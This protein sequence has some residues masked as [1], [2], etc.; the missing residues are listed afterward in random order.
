MRLNEQ[1]PPLAKILAAIPLVVRGAHADYTHLSWT[2][3]GSGKFPF[4]Q[5]FLGEWVFGHWFLMTWNDPH[6]TL[7]WARIPMLLLTL[8]L[9]LVP[10][11]MG[12]R[13]GD[14]WGGLLCLAAY[15]TMPPFLAFGP[16]VITDLAVTFILGADR[17]AAA[18]HV[19]QS[20]TRGDHQVRL[21]SGRS[22]LSKFSSGLCSSYF[23]HSR[24]V[25][26]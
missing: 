2:F 11:V 20:L 8:L 7:Y 16:L 1:H 26:A 5:Q 10:Y 12:T 24:S 18:E 21:D 6:T 23:L 14:V 25:C 22:L 19:A 15:T 3:S 9:G 13:L 4:F 17:M